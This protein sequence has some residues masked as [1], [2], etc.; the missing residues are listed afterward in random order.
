M[1]CCNRKA[2]LSVYTGFFG[3]SSA[4]KHCGL[5]VV[6]TL[7]LINTISL[8]RMH[9]AALLAYL[10]GSMLAVNA[11]QPI[12]HLSGKNELHWCRM[13]RLKRLLVNTAKL[14]STVS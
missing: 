7:K 8:L 3:C 13:P 1:K 11:Q 6:L 4:K 5:S 10:S 2:S 9:C 12:R 14:D